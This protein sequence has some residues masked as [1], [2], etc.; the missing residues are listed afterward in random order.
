VKRKLQ[1]FVLAALAVA[2][3]FGWWSDGAEAQRPA[4]RS[5]D[6]NREIRPIISDNC[7]TCHGPDE[8]QR[9]ARLRLDT[10]DGAFAKAGL[11]VAGDPAASRLYQRISAADVSQRMPPPDS[12]HALT[13]AQ[14]ELIRQWIAQGAKWSTH[15]AYDAPRRPELPAV[16]DASRAPNPIDRFI[17][18]RLEREGL[19]LSPEAD[20]ATL[21][22]R[23][24]LDLTGLPPTAAEL[25]AFLAD[26]SPNAYEKQVD[27][28]LASPH[29]GERMAMM[30][31]DLARYADTHG[32]HIDSH[33]DM[34]PYRDWLIRAFNRDLSYDQFTVEQLA[35]DLLPQA[36]IDQQIASGFN[37][38]HMINFEG[39]AIPEEYQTEYVIDRVEA[40]STTW[41]GMTMGCARC[42]THKYDP[43]TQK[44]FYQFFAFFNTVSEEGLDGRVGNAKPMLRLP[45]DEQKAQT[46]R[47]N[48]SIS[49]VEEKLSDKQIAPVQEAWEQPYLGKHATAPRDGLIAH[50]ELDNSFVDLSGRYKH[51]RVIR[52]DPTFG[53]GVIGRAVSFDGDTQVTLG[54]V[55]GDARQ[56]VGDFDRG[57]KFSIA[58]WVRGGSSQPITVMQK[59][60]DAQTRRGYEFLIEDRELIGIQRFSQRII[61]RFISQWPDAA[62]TMRTRRRIPM[63]EWHHVTVTSDG[64]GR[65]AGLKLYL[66]G[67]LQEVDVAKDS[68]NGS[69][70]ND[71]PFV[72]GDPTLGKAYRG[73]LDDLRFY[74]RALTGPEVEELA[75]HYP[76]QMVLSGVF[77]KRSKE[78]AT[79]LREY[80]LQRAASPE[81][82][83]AAVE[84]KR[85]KKERDDLNKDILTVMVMS[86]MEKPRDT[87]ILGRGDYRNKTE[88]VTADV[89]AV[90]PPLA[91]NAPH[92]RLTLARWLVD[93]QHPLTARVA[94][95]RFWALYFGNGIV[96]T[97]EDFGSQGEP[98]VHPELLDYLATEFIRTGWG[99]KA[100]QKLIVTS[101]A[102]RQSSK[103]TRGLWEK[104]PENRLLARGPRQ[105]LQAELI[106][107]L[108][109]AASGLINSK[110]GGPSVSPYQP[111]GLWEEMAFGDGFSAQ[112]YK[113]SRGQDLY[114]RSMYT[115]WKRTVPPATMSIFDAPDREKCTARRPVTNTPLQALALLNDP[116]YVEA[117]RA[118]AARTINEGGRDSAS[119]IG[120][121]F[122]L[123]TA[124][125]PSA[126]ESS[127]LRALLDKELAHYRRER[128][129]AQSLLKVG[130]SAVDQKM[131]VAELAAWTVVTSAILNLDETVT[132]E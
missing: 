13:P 130:E 24:S 30:W 90:L 102:Y 43:I 49:A 37:R 40:T 10:R 3:C 96:K 63:S 28:L 68:L 7:F 53:G 50:Y 81:L 65:A 58:F 80:F 42:H 123:A 121:A 8:K 39:G 113:Q 48:Q 82:R 120:Y 92:N 6:F 32:Y 69:T 60:S 106:R 1:F 35:G 19:A 23:V 4:E 57:D 95:N 110:I 52:G 12:G 33:R 76:T 27:R 15:W 87:Y 72:I 118:L 91:K 17:V 85:L 119:R 34:W 31:L 98:P 74:S 29:Y 16:K 62:I 77:G 2:V 112:E 125:K 107:D 117:A 78:D 131:D 45:T 5:I 132:K 73:G 109:L 108:A 22:R 79:R 75:I 127:V 70:R 47:L 71:A 128:N 101:S 51:G 99:V 54:D 56:K 105:R 11:I 46:E 84:L 20:K 26:S 83:A 38:N 93:P 111:A 88:K 100:L 67:E 36:T 103:V 55:D 129:A 116:T 18:A 25:D 41:L 64:S 61:F 66:D 14:I 94:V 9:M 89:P 126:Q 104:D 124:R 21:L 44:E 114:R 86:E 122:R 59:L 115:F 97:I